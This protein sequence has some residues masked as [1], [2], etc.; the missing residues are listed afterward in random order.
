M[1]K[2][3]HIKNSENEALE[4]SYT[5]QLGNKWYS[6]VNLLDISPARGIAAARADRYV[7]MRI[8]QKNLF[9]L[10]GVAIDGINKKQDHVQATAIIHEIKHR[11]EFLCEENSILDLAGIYYFLEDE[12]PDFP[13]ERHAELKKE[14]WGK[15]ELCRG[16]FLHMGLSITKQFSGTPEEDLVRFLMNPIT[17]EI[18]ERMYNWIPRP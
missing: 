4:C 16:F 11:E 18:H 13:S 14:I 12:D 9:D 15:D 1:S 8:S 7:G 2:K 5:D 3:A 10:L 17:K 6:H